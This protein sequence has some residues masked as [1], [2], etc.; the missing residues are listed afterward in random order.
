MGASSI[1]ASPEKK[2]P[3]DILEKV[4]IE[5][6]AD[7]PGWFSGAVE[8]LYYEARV[9]V[10]LAL[11]AQGQSTVPDPWEDFYKHFRPTR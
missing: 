7:L 10:Y 11:P 8:A 6:I 4:G 3:M 1:R 9:N 5:E 2:G